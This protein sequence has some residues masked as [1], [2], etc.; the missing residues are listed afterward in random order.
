MFI[1]ATGALSQ[2]ASHG[3]NFTQAADASRHVLRCPGGATITPEAGARYS[4]L[5]RNQDGNA[6]GVILRRKALLV[7]VE[8]GRAPGFVVVTPQAIAAV[9]GT[10]WAVDVLSGKTAV[11]VVDGR[12]DVQRPSSSAGV[13]LGPGE[14]VDVERGTSPLIVKRWPAARVS[15]LLARLG[16]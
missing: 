4:T 15:A 7:E 6:D 2:S 12:V 8:S 1:W 16:E 14:G 10:K 13:V 3:C 11:F 9:R 5:D